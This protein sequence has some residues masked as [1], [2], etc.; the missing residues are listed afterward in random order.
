M[1]GSP[2]TI[3]RSVTQ[4]SGLT[5]LSRVLGL[6]REVLTSRLVGA[7]LEQSAFVFAFTLPNLFRKLF[8]E[9]ALSS[10]FVPVFKA[11]LEHGRQAEAERLA[12]AV[13]SL[14]F[15]M[16]AGVCAVAIGGISLVLP[17]LAPDGRLAVTLRLTRIMLPYAVM[18]CTAAFSMGVLNALGRFGHAAFAPSILNLVWIA[19]LAALFAFPDLSVFDRVRIVSYAVLVSGVLQMVY[20]LSVVR[21]SGIRLGLTFSGWRNPAV[22]PVWRNT[23]I[24]ALGMG[25]VQIN[26]VFDNALALWAAP[27]GPAAIAYAERLV[28]LPLGVIA[29]AFATV[30]LPTLA[31]SFARGEAAEAK[32]ILRRAAED[33]LLLTLPAA[34]GLA[35]LAPDVTRVVYQGGAFTAADTLYVSRA[36][37]CYAPGLLVFSMNKILTPWFHARQDMKTPLKVAVGMVV[38]NAS[39]NVLFVL[40]LPQGW[41][42]AGIAGSTVFCSLVSCVVLVWLARRGAGPMGLRRLLRPFSR[43]LAAAGVMGVVVLAVRAGA[44]HV[45]GA[46]RAAAVVALAGSVA[47]GVLVYGVGVWL[48]CP[49]TLRR[50]LMRR[51]R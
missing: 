32:G 13:A 19:T 9:G 7:G 40:T 5:G 27:W 34:L 24:G 12:R 51:A 16:L 37:L 43:M 28:Y 14:V 26:L 18:I 36:L 30:L 29:T 39:L 48:G 38:A 33:V 25:A 23:F 20:L 3:N 10:A 42:H 8:G 17:H 1:S 35:L 50:V 46:G 21:R 41:K 47:S 31:A 44:Y 6:L 49:E 22:S 15:L 4:V 2:T 45:W 11:Q